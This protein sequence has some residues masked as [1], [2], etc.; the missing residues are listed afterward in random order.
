[1][2]EVK[3]FTT[4]DHSAGLAFTFETFLFVVIGIVLVLAVAKTSE[5]EDG[6]V[7]VLL[8][9]NLPNLGLDNIQVPLGSIISAGDLFINFVLEPFDAVV[10]ATGTY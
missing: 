6:F 4:F 7:V 1:M 2:M 9:N 3:R 8:G 10:T 5:E